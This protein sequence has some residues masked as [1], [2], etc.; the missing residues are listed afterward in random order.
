MLWEPM[1]DNKVHCFLCRHHCKI[2]DGKR[3][4]CHVRE[5]RDG[6]LYTLVY[7]RVIAE[8]MDPIEKKPLFHFYP[9]SYSYSIATPGCNFK[10]LFCQNADISQMPADTSLIAGRPMPPED[11][12]EEA[13]RQ[14]CK[15]I[16][17]TYTEPTIFFEL[18]Y[19]TARIAH[20]RGIKNVFVTNGYIT[21]EALA[22]I[23]PYLDAANID[24]KGFSETFYRKTCGA[25]LENVL[26]SIRLYHELGIWVEITTLIIPDLNDSREELEG[27]AGFIASIDKE[28]PWHVT[29]FHP[30]YKLMDKP[31]T[32]VN[33]LRMA[34]QIG[35]DAGLKYVY[36]GNVPGE[37][38]ENTY[39][40]EC[41]QLLVDR[42]GY[43]I[44]KYHIIDG[45]CEYCKAKIA[46][47]GV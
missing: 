32:A 41:K 38:G 7:D 21:G 19:D 37:G 42:F 8:H 24:L 33:T 13:I 44:S 27:I 20:K 39:C 6:R 23:R 47:V 35:Q 4:I 11:I 26:E 15:S 29:Q 30:T 46:G 40:P 31:R 28:I 45:K 25:K 12:V 43:I 34:R 22:E 17:Y 3:G 9:R 18:A 16:S 36:E 2:P 1:A 14:R 10:C 5:N